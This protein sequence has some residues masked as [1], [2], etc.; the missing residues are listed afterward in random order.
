MPDP[1]SHPLPEDSDALTDRLIDLSLRETLGG[2][3]P[4]DLTESILAA[5]HSAPP[6]NLS[7]PLGE[8]KMPTTNTSRRTRSAIWLTLAAAASLSAVA[9]FLTINAARSTRQELAA[10]RHPL[11]PSAAHQSP[12]SGPLPV[13]DVP[14][15][16]EAIAQHPAQ[17][18]LLGGGQAS[19]DATTVES[20]RLSREAIDGDLSAAVLESTEAVRG[21]AKSPSADR[22]SVVELYAADERSARDREVGQPHSGRVSQRAEL[23]ARRAE[24]EERG[25]DADGTFAGGEKR[26]RLELGDETLSAASPSAPAE[27]S[28]GRRPWRDSQAPTPAAQAPVPFYRLGGYPDSRNRHEPAPLPSS[29][30]MLA[31]GVQPG[32]PVP[33]YEIPRDRR[34]DRV[35]G[36]GPGRGG[37]RYERIVENAFI[38][39]SEENLST[40]SIDVDTASYANV[41]Q[42]L[43]HSGMLPPPDAVRIEELVNYFDYEYAPPSAAATSDDSPPFAAHIETA[44]SPW[45]PNHRLVRIGIKGLEVDRRARP[46]S[47]LVFLIDV[48]GSMNEPNKLPLLVQG[49]KLLTRELGENDRVAIVVYA[50]S[51]GLALP[52]TPGSEQATLLAALDK[53]RAGGSTAGGAG[54]ELA[55]ETAQQHFIEG[56]VNRVILCTDGDFNVGVT[57]PAAL[58]RMAQERAK[59]SGVFLTVIGFGRGNLNDAMMER[60]SGKGNGNYYY[61][62]NLTEARKVLVEE[63]S[64]TLVTIAKD[65]KLQVDFN[66]A[67]V[68]GYRLIGYEN[69]ALAK[70]DFND[71]TKDAGEI[72]AGHSV[73]ALYEI[74]P[75]GAP[76]PTPGVDPSKY[77]PQ[78]NVLPAANE[79]KEL[80]TLRIRYKPPMGDK[81]TKLEFAVTDGGQSFAEASRDF[82]FASAVAGFGMLLRHSAHSGNATLSG[83]LEIAESA[84]SGHDPHGYRAEFLQMVQAA[85]ALE[86]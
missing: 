84:S 41:R 20:R 24:G 9:G 72:G 2:E 64:G 47:N 16:N 48:S 68:A 70:Q 43:L 31:R 73:T 42:F 80:L 63:M 36:I 10:G 57:S 49:M 38:R 28:A 45:A 69:R 65:V 83:I 62:D 50:S 54:I 18:V 58:E 82:Q 78:R 86:K 66:P 27:A 46:L 37:D 51:E 33:G 22:S 1:T 56:G 8:T 23:P 32:Q 34:W 4:P 75:A 79:S 5:A 17:G 81:S 55:Y 77:V 21:L 3:V 39:T 19:V 29:T 71:D 15:Q 85:I 6:A 35:E 7:Q 61:V 12:S 60:I 14:A 59:Q 40:F 76:V 11:L 52:S 74:I 53:L 44:A 26:E 30:D 25:D 13:R 67:Q